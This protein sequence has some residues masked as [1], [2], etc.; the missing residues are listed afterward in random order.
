MVLSLCSN[1]D[2]DSFLPPE[3]YSF[4]NHNESLVNQ[5]L[6][7]Q[8]TADIYHDFSPAFFEKQFPDEELRNQRVF[9]LLD[10]DGCFIGS[11]AIWFGGK[12]FNDSV[13]RLHWLAVLPEYQGK[14]LG[15]VIL[16]ES[17]RRFCTLSYKKVYLST[18]TLRPAAISLYA[19]FG[20]K[21][22][23]S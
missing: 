9:Y 12:G 7:I 14:G 6:L 23:I 10:G 4:I 19:K 13:G 18:S 15:K 21:Q 20:F 3:K 22:I 1:Y 2:A 16:S 8:S 11:A 5:W 17:I